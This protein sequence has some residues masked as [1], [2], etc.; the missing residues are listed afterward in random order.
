MPRYRPRY[1]QHIGVA[2][3]CDK[4]DAEP[5]KVVV[6]IIERVDFELA[7]VARTG[8]DVT[9]RQR[10]AEILQDLPV[11]LLARRAKPLIVM[12]RRLGLDAGGC[13]LFQ[14]LIHINSP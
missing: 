10:A 14:Y 7:T 11:Q 12:R 2:R 9:Y 6:G 5:F 1:E 4:F 8:V 13:D 3:A